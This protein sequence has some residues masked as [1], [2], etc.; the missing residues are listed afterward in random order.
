MLELTP[1]EKDNPVPLYYQLK[2]KI[3]KEIQ[4]GMHPSSIPL[5]PEEKIAAMCGISRTTVRQAI[6]ELVKEGWL[7]RVKAK[8]TFVSCGR[9]GGSIAESPDQYGLVVHWKGENIQMEVLKVLVVP[10]K[11]DSAQGQSDAACQYLV[12]TV[13][14]VSCD[15]FPSALFHIYQMRA[16]G[17]TSSIQRV[18]HVLRTMESS[19]E[20]RS[21]LGL[22]YT[23]PM[24][25]VV[26]TAFNYQGKV[27]EY[28]VSRYCGSMCRVELVDLN[29][30]NG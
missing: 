5:P 19:E 27:F 1:L 6:N 12:Y 9:A 18:H 26:T 11:E 28:A 24:Q 14:R 15:G 13:K 20:D 7:Y 29:L 22:E 16:Y 23:E 10:V 17:L 4:K 3:L 30:K 21:L 25:E 2:T 8:G